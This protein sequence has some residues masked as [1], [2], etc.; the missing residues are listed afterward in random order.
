MFCNPPALP[1][2]GIPR[3]AIEQALSYSAI[4]QK[5]AGQNRESVGIIAVEGD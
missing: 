1:R 2:V 5:G 3:N 4:K